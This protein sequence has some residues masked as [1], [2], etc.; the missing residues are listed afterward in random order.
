MSSF[1]DDPIKDLGFVVFPASAG[2][3]QRDCLFCAFSLHL[4]KSSSLI[5]VGPCSNDG[6]GITT[7][8][9]RQRKVVKRPTSNHHSFSKTSSQ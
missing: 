8:S 5:A 9:S 6:A 1:G 4:W 3:D 7:P 2:L